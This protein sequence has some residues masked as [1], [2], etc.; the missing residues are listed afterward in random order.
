VSKNINIRDAVSINKPSLLIPLSSSDKRKKGKCS[1]LT[2]GPILMSVTTDKGGYLAG[3][4]IAISVRVENHGNRRITGIL[5]I[6]T[7]VIDC[8]DRGRGETARKYR[9]ALQ[10]RG[11]GVEPGSEIIWDSRLMYL[12]VNLTPTISNCDIISLSYILKVKAVVFWANDFCVA[13]PIVIGNISSDNYQPPAT[14]PEFVPEQSAMIATN[15]FRPP[16]TNPAFTDGTTHPPANP[17]DYQC[18]EEKMFA[19]LDGL[20][21]NYESTQPLSYEAIF[22]A[23]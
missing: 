9:I 19:P 2:S 21:T 8:Y 15:N 12:P 18:Q 10:I 11:P 3:D 16:A 23:T 7:E 17:Q 20:V 13:I 5:A 6:L 14:N 1:C 4:S 22:N